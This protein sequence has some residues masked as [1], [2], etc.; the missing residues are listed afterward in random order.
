MRMHA[1]ARSGRTKVDIRTN[2][3][4]YVQGCQALARRGR[5]AYL[6]C[7]APPYPNERKAEMPN[8][9]EGIQ[10]KEFNVTLTV[11]RAKLAGIKLDAPVTVT[12]SLPYVGGDAQATAKLYKAP[13]SVVVNGFV[14]N[15]V[16]QVQEGCRNALEKAIKEDKPVAKAVQDY[17]D[18]RM[19]VGKAVRVSR[20]TK[21][22]AEIKAAGLSKEAEAAAL[23]A[24]ANYL[25]KEL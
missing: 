1:T 17:V 9:V 18:E 11:A 20:W 22:Q 3:S 10:H 12:C 4:E 19:K 15:T 23:A 21:A 7:T 6:T 24:V 16:V 5:N 13:E 25:G 2:V 8:N 14:A